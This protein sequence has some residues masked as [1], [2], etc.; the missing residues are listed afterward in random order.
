MG[1]ISLSDIQPAPAEA[2]ALYDKYRPLIAQVSAAGLSAKKL[3]R[4][5]L[6]DCLALKSNCDVYCQ[7]C[8]DGVV[9]YLMGCFGEE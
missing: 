8:I 6:A 4:E 5:L 9:D 2:V 7:D 1:V 3:K